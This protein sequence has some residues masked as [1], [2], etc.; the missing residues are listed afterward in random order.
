M[1]TNFMSN[2][3]TEINPVAV[4]SPWLTLRPFTISSMLLLFVIP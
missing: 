1:T 4:N 2:T 3:E